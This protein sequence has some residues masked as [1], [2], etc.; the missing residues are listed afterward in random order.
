MSIGEKIKTRRRELG[1]TQSKVAGEKISRNMLSLI[2]SGNASPSLETLEYIAKKLKLRV[3]YLIS[4]DIPLETF[5]RID[6]ESEI[7]NA[8]QRK[9]YEKVVNLVDSFGQSSDILMHLACECA[10]RIAEGK[11][12]G[13]SLGSAKG[14][15]GRVEEY[16]SHTTFDTSLIRAKLSVLSAIVQNIQSPKLNFEQEPYEALIKEV[17]SEEYY[18]YF[19][20]DISYTYQSL[21]LK[22]HMDAKALMR[23]RNYTGAIALLCQAEDEKNQENYD[24]YV[25]FGIYNDLENCYKEI[26]DFEKAYRY[27]TKKMSMMEYFKS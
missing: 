23:N 22:L 10:Y 5:E 8:Y 26:L 3:E 24:A 17:T 19:I 6:H 11:V 27:A 2:E 9:D 7:L 25:F 4:S 20:G 15:I 18:H 14:W 13:G 1:L 12:H 16:M 21:I